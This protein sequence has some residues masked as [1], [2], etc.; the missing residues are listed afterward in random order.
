LEEAVALFGSAHTGDYDFPFSIDEGLRV[1]RIAARISKLLTLD[2]LWTSC[3]RRNKPEELKELGSVVDQ[4]SS[5]LVHLAEDAEALLTML[6]D[7]REERLEAALS[8]V[9]D[10]DS[11]EKLR[12]LARREGGVLPMIRRG[13]REA[14][15]T[16][17]LERTSLRGEYERLCAGQKSGGDLRPLTE[18]GLGLMEM[19]F[20]SFLLSDGCIRVARSCG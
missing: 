8:R 6:R 3:A 14:G 12:V 20:G 7:I 9:P 5:L 13:L 4:M 10:T 16:F 18:C 19:G 11:V 15:E 1:A 17:S 2:A